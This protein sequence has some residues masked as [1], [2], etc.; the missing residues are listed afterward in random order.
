M[1]SG[2]TRRARTILDAWR[3]RDVLRGR[4]VAW[5]DGSGVADG[6]D[7]RGSLLVITPGGE[8]LALGAG[9]VHLSGA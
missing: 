9:E 8:R 4:E 3:K 1:I 7:D 2:S 6:I 5:S